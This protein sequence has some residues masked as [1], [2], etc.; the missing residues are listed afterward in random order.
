MLEA[1]PDKRIS[2]EDALK[3]PFLAKITLDEIDNPLD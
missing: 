1:D 3:H 2:P